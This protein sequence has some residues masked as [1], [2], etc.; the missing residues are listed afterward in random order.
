MIYTREIAVRKWLTLLWRLRSKIC[1]HEAGD[2][3]EPLVMVLF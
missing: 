2:P 3:G 1:S